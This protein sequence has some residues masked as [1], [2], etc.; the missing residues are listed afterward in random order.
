[1]LNGKVA[2]VTGSNAGIGAAIVKELSSRGASVVV[3]YPFPNVKHEAEALISTCQTACIGIEAD[4]S[5]IHGP[6]ALID[7]AVERFGK[8]DILINN[9]STTIL[10]PLEKATLQDWDTMLNLNGRAYLLTTQAALPH[11]NNP[12]RIVNIISVGARAPT[13][14]ST[15]YAATKGMQ[16]VFTKLWARE[17]PPKYGCT[18]NAVSPG[19]TRY[20]SV[21]WSFLIEVHLQWKS[22]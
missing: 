5:T 15:I 3:N 10:A 19:A 14:S 2:I 17:L 22:S 21:L 8:I 13:V 18:V 16:D 20:I 12:S 1:M 11:L 7:A 9:A 6:K 4:L